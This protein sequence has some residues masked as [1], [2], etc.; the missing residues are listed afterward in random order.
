LS[1]WGSA[2]GYRCLLVGLYGR[3]PVV[4]RNKYKYLVA[5]YSEEMR[6]F[7]RPTVKA[8]HPMRTRLLP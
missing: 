5:T 2:M 1:I 8:A 3:V 6:L 4:F 7:S